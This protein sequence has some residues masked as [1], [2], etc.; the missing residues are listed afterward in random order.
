MDHTIT[1]AQQHLDSW[2]KEKTVV[3]EKLK[4]TLQ[5]VFAYIQWKVKLVKFLDEVGR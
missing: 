5:L 3:F 1:A 4:L 2:V